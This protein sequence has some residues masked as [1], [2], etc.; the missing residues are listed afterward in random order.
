M[1]G[2]GT[3]LDD[4]EGRVEG[5]GRRI[6]VVVARFNGHVTG[7]LLEGVR[8]ALREHGVAEEDVSVLRV[9][10]AWEL[11]QAAQRAAVTGSYDA[12]VALGCVIRGETA[13]FDFIAGEAARGL[14]AVAR[15]TGVPVI[16]GVLT[17]DTEEQ[18]LRRADPDGQ[19]KG[20]EAALSALEMAA[21]FER[22]RNG[23][24]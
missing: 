18:A 19:D 10:G 1:S 22:M 23:E 21:L 3:Y 15:A 14:G 20:R 16:F 17:T 2:P 8:E 6:A 5:A 13:H 7:R 11:P 9:P 12:V 24:R 4:L